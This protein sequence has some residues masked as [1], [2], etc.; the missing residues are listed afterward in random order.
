MPDGALTM[1]THTSVSASQDT[2]AATV[3]RWSMSASQTL[4]AMVLHAETTREHMS[5][6]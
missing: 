4:V 5:V 6:L 3:M 2:Q 1:G